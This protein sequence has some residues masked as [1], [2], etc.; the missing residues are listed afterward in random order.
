MP[1]VP[2]VR[3]LG[4][5]DV[6]VVLTLAVSALVQVWTLPS[7]AALQGGRAAHSVLVAA[8]TLPLLL[9]RRHALT[10]FA[11][12]VA[13]AWLQFQLGGELGQPFFAVGLALYAV[14]AHAPMPSA[15]V[16]PA[17]V[18]VQIVL[19]DVPRLRA[20]DA[21]DE[22]APAWFIL[23]A[24]WGFGRWMRHRASEAA[25]LTER[26][27]AAERDRHANAARAVADERARIA[28]ELHDLVAHS[29]ACP[30]CR[31]YSSIMSTSS[32]RSDDTCPLPPW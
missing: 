20:G 30:V 7:D 23:L 28:R 9:R 31:A 2:R 26:A 24:G 29:S 5:L 10:V 16:G 4:L 22:V 15:L 13:S 1:T 32:R 18:V 11:F 3:M 14:G 21:V 17:S 6:V 8:C 27:E 19:V 25:T 12:V